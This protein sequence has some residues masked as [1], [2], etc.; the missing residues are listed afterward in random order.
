LKDNSNSPTN[1]HKAGLSKE[2]KPRLLGNAFNNAVIQ[3]SAL[4]QRSQSREMEKPVAA[5]RL[6]KE[7]DEENGE[8]ED[9]E[10]KQQDDDI[11]G[12]NPKSITTVKLAFEKRLKERKSV[13]ASHKA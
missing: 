9:E 12:M 4:D 8:E 13:I 6:E 1:A 5:R 10:H 2:A 7:E 3:K 11:M